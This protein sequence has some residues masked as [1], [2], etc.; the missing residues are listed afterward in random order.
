[1][2]LLS[3]AT[4]AAQ[5]ERRF[6]QVLEN[7]LP[8][9]SVMIGLGN[10][11]FDLLSNQSADRDSVFRGDDL[12]APNGGLVELNCEVAAA[13]A[14]ILRG[15]RKARKGQRRREQRRNWR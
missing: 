12:S 2:E 15:A 8:R 11:L 3:A 9:G 7:L 13:H 10:H 6:L 5:P 1:M 4:C 14:R